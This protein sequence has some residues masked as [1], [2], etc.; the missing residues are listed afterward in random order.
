MKKKKSS[1]CIGNVI[2]KKSINHFDNFLGCLFFI[3][4]KN[5]NTQVYPSYK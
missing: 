4:I 2:K 1:Y 3:N 5:K